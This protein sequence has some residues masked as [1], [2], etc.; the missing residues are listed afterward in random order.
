[1]HEG[2]EDYRRYLDPGALA[3]VASLD[4]RARLLAQGFMTG[5][6]R[7]PIHGF[8]VEFAEHRKYCQGDDLRFIDWKVYGRTD[9][10]YIK[11]HEQETNLRLL[12]LVDCSDS[13]NYRSANAPMSKR[14][15]AIT[16]AAVI[17]YLALH[18][19]DAV[20][21]ATFDTRLRRAHRT[22]N[23]PGQWKAIIR[24]L[25]HA[26]HVGR[27][28][29]RSVFDE[30][31]ESLTE[32]HLVVIL[33]DLFSPLEDILLGIKHVRHRRHEPLVLQTLDPAE[34]TFPF[35]GP[36]E[37]V[38]L[39]EAGAQRTDP[40]FAR[41]HYL[42][43]LKRFTDSIRR[44]CLEQRVD[45]QLLDTAAPVGPALSRYLATRAART[46]SRN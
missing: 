17:A 30:L 16:I 32:R 26:E 6:H 14:D 28:S 36:T 2:A 40:H 20:G 34:L 4:L 33:G 25:E 44:G 22:T 24:E 43:E 11:E 8:S 45:Y 1:M 37:F 9:K 31:S 41:Q 7:S 27:T 18:Q 10:H 19:S 12:I 15:Y 46:R 21:V 3:S 39:E 23:Q 42:D 13:M 38:G 5:L 29:L 35:D